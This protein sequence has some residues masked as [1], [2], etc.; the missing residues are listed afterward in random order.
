[1]QKIWPETAY[2]DRINIGD[3][4][5]IFHKRCYLQVLI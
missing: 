2:Y 5:H 1:M 4:Q 3:H